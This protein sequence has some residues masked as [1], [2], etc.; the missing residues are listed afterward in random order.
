M[1]VYIQEVEKAAM[2]FVPSG[3]EGGLHELIHCRSSAAARLL[4]SAHTAAG[5]SQPPEHDLETPRTVSDAEV[6]WTVTLRLDLLQE[7]L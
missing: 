4:F 7:S 3:V 2:L 1:T 5:T 6:T